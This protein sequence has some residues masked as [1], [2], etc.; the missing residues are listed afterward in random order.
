MNRLSLS[1]GEVLAIND[2]LENIEK[3]LKHQAPADADAIMT[4]EQVMKFLSV[5][6]RCLQGWRDKG[7]IMYSA[8]QGKF[9][10]RLS[11]IN[12]MLNNHQ[13]NKEVDICI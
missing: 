12:R 9:Y 1:P 3:L 13:Q 11:A 5:S 8:V 7:L 4:T 6:R 10:Y 2:R